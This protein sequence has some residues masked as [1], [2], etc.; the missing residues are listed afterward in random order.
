MTSVLTALI[1]AAVVLIPVMAACFWL[2]HPVRRAIDAWTANQTR[3]AEERDA[4]T[5]RAVMEVAERSHELAVRQATLNDETAAAQAR[6][7]AETAQYETDRAAAAQVLDEAVQARRKVI[8]ARAAAEAELAPELARA[9]LA[10]SNG[11]LTELRQAY[12]A[13]CNACPDAPETFAEWIGDFQGL[14][15]IP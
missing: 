2:A 3:T 9:S 6:L 12:A 11:E 1:W 5:Q 4:D 7:A 15:S 14:A 13:Y 10:S 8:A